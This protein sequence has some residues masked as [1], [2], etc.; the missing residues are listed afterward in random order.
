MNINDYFNYLAP[1]F[2]NTNPFGIELSGYNKS[3]NVAFDYCE[4]TTHKETKNERNAHFNKYKICKQNNT[5]LFTIC[6]DEW[7]YKN[8]IVKIKL[9]HLFNKDPHKKVFARKCILNEI[10][11]EYKKAFLNEYHIQG[12]CNS[13]IN[14][15]LFYDNEIVAVMSFLNQNNTAFELARYATKYH[16]VG[17]FGKLLKHFISNYEWSKILSFADLRWHTGE[18]YERTGFK[19]EKIIVPDY[20]YVIGDKRQHKFNFRL[21]KIQRKFPG[22]FDPSLTEHENMKKLNIPRIYDCGKARF[23]LKN[24]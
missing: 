8:E 9:A 13:S 15:G 2:A 4:L 14:Y 19:L 21:K 7:V 11:L 18:V 3:I 16:V 20:Q 23:V 5:R 12:N 1:G 24:E 17:G 6:E 10:S 22:S